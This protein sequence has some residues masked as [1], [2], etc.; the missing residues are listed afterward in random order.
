[1][2]RARATRCRATIADGG[3]RFAWVIAYKNGAAVRLS[4]V[5]QVNDGVENALLAGWAD[6]KRAIILNVQRQPGAN[7]IEVADRVKA[8]PG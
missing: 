5:A 7:V 4:D 8:L 6:D 2:A 1:M 3:L